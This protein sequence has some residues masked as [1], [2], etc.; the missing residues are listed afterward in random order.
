MYFKKTYLKSLV[1]KK[2]IEMNNNSFHFT[3]SL[4]YKKSVQLEKNDT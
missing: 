4:C 1:V 2:T 3:F